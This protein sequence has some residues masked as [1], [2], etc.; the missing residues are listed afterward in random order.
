[1]VTLVSISVRAQI[2]HLNIC[3]LQRLRKWK[4]LLQYTSLSVFVVSESPSSVQFELKS[5]IVCVVIA[6]VRLYNLREPYPTKD[7]NLSCIYPLLAI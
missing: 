5:S 3:E 4:V 6:F 1:M 2:Q 7:Q